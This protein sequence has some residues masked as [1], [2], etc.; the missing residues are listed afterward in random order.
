MPIEPDIPAADTSCVGSGIPWKGIAVT[1]QVLRRILALA[2]WLAALLTVAGCTGMSDYVRNGFRVGPEYRKPAALIADD[3]IDSSDA[4]LEPG[5][6]NCRQWWSIFQDPTL[7]RL[8]ALAYQ[9]NISLREAGFRVVEVRELRAVVAGNLFPQ[10]QEAIWRFRP[11]TAQR[12]HGH[13]SS[14]QQPDRVGQRRSAQSQQLAAGCRSGVG[15][16]FL[17]SVSP[18]DRSGRCPL[19]Q[20]RREL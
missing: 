9:Q 18:R 6:A 2:L 1:H 13:L 17:G 11:N 8:I 5:P 20:F 7:D 14:F 3:W 4:R 10:T 19:E 15:I 12:Q 16:G